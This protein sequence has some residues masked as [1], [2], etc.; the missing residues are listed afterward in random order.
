[1][2]THTHDI[3][4]AQT[5]ATQV[6]AAQAEA[7]N[8]AIAALTVQVQATA[9]AVTALQQQIVAVGYNNVARTRNVGANPNWTPLR[10]EVAGPNLNTAPPNGFP[11][12]MTAQITCQQET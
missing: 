8:Q 11:A 12:N 3:V 7:M 9:T 5:Q 4:T 10:C 1:M 2:Q 6:I